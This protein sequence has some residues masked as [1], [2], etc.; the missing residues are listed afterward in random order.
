MAESNTGLAE[1]YISSYSMCRVEYDSKSLTFPRS[2]VLVVGRSKSSDF[3][4][5][6]TQVSRKHCE[7]QYSENGWILHNLSTG[8]W[9]SGKI[10]R[11]S[12]PINNGDILLLGDIYIQCFLSIDN[13]QF[14]P[15]NILRFEVLVGKDLCFLNTEP[16]EAAGNKPEYCLNIDNK[17]LEVNE[18]DGNAQVLES[19]DIERRNKALLKQLEDCNKALMEVMTAKMEADKEITLLREE[20][21]HQKESKLPGSMQELVE[22]ELQCSVCNELIINATTLA[23]SHTF[24]EYCL[25]RWKKKNNICPICRTGITSY[26][27]TRMIDNLIEKLLSE[28]PSDFQERRKDLIQAREEGRKSTK[29][30]RPG[31]NRRMNNA[32]VH[33]QAITMTLHG[34]ANIMDTTI[35]LSSEED[36]P[37]IVVHQRG[38]RE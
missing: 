18:M 9:L 17:S 28:L 10:I 27:K 37:V 32:N 24:C 4:V 11:E 6:V 16:L 13:S 33:R 23:C 35:D 8:T 12:C 29:R 30:K 22:N 20:L 2:R 14:F 19:L 7:I 38:R 34:F 25:L 5:A 26:C 1:K 31:S 36:S 21:S 3:R 15:I